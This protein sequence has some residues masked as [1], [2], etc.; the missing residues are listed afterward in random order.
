MTRAAFTREL[1]DVRRQT[2]VAAAETVL[3]RE[4]AAGTS[5]RAICAEAGYDGIMIRKRLPSSMLGT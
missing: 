3:A 5:V 1:P 2:L 4:G